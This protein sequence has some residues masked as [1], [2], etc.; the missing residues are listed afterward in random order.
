MASADDTSFA[1]LC[2]HCQI[3]FVAEFIRNGILNGL[4]L[5]AEIEQ[6]M[7]SDDRL[8]NMPREVYDYVV[9]WQHGAELW[10]HFDWAEDRYW[11]MC[12]NRAKAGNESSSCFCC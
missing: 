6:V 7:A 4:M 3:G 5:C 11:K 1:S 2:R 10:V 12:L 8:R 9:V